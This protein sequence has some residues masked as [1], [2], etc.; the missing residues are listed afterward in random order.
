MSSLGSLPPYL[1]T[2][3]ARGCHGHCHQ[4]TLLIPL[5]LKSLTSEI[6]KPTNPI[7]IKEIMY[8]HG[9]PMI[10]WEEVDNMIIQENLRQNA[11]LVFKIQAYGEMR[12]NHV[13]TYIFSY[14]QRWLFSY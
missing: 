8:V 12:S 7:P 3:D 6:T 5:Y 2:F 4:S 13:K 14:S 9:E 10:L 11:I 1:P